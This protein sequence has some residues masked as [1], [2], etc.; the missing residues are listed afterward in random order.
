MYSKE[1]IKIIKASFW[2]GFKA[3]SGPRRRKLGKNKKWVMQSTGIKALDL[4]FHINQQLAS[5]SVDIVSKSLETKVNYWNKLLGLKTILNECFTQEV[6]WDDMFELESGKEIIRIGVYLNDV[7]ILDKQC[8]EKVYQFFFEN[9][10]ILEDWLEEY[11]DIIRVS[12]QQNS[13]GY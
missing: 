7:N 5:V 8:W 3:Y 13:T 11:I 10:I 1:E 4:K 9:M 6:I 12:R 2:D